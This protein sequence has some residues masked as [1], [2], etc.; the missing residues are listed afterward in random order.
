MPKVTPNSALIQS[1]SGAIGDLVFYRDAEGDLIVQRK[2]ERKAPPSPKQVARREL[3]KLA[4]VYGNRVK[5]NAVLSA[6]YRPLCRGRMGPYQVAL[7]DFMV[8]PNV[9][10]I[11]LQGFTGQ[12]GQLIRIMA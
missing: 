5:A 10:G 4:S 7:R 12:P 9:A 1:I 6:E 8:P 11:D 2:G 3:L